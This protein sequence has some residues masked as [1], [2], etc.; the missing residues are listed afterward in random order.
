MAGEKRVT[1][2]SVRRSGASEPGAASAS[3]SV[4]VLIKAWLWSSHCKQCYR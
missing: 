4:C 1:P 3:A 2:P